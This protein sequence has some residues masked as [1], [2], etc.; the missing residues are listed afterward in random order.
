MKLTKYQHACFALEHDGQTLVVDPGGFTRD[1]SQPDNVVAVVVTHM[2]G[3]HW[4]AEHLRPLSGVPI[5]AP[6]D[7]VEA[8]RQSGIEAIAVDAGDSITAGNFSLEFCGGQHAII[9]PMQSM[10]A[11][12]GLLVNDRV[13]YPGDSFAEPPRPVD[14]LLVPISAPWCKTAEAM[15]FLMQIRPRLAIPTHDGVLSA[16]GKAV[17]DAWMYK[18]AEKVGCDYR[19]LDGESITLP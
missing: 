12:L 16:D 13:Y 2:H 6:A 18:A 4:S 9:H 5:Y 11:N 3:D 1:Y 14:T 15:D 10:C 17:C 8:M 19:R 7:A